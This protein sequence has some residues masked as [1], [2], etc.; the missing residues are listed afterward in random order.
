MSGLFL[1]KQKAVKL[2]AFSIPLFVGIFFLAACGTQPATQAAS[3]VPSGSNLSG[4]GRVSNSKVSFAND[5]MPILKDTCIKCHGGEK[6]EK[7]LDMT[8]YAAL[9]NGSDNGAVVVP[10]DAANSSFIHLF[11]YSFGDEWENAEARR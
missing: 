7:G 1:F 9:M 6:T 2:L 8:T 4:A 10:G 11:I 5:V 3:S